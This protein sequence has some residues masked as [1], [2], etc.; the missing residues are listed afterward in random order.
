MGLFAKIN[1]NKTNIGLVIWGA[2][3]LVIA[4]KPGIGTYLPADIVNTVLM[5]WLGY[6]VRDAWKKLEK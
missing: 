1:G 6:S 5:A 4:F 3:N 2:Y